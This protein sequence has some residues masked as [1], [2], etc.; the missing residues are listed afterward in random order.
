MANTISGQAL[1]G[2]TITLSGTASAVT[3][4]GP[5]GTY[6]F[7]GLAAGAY[8]V[9]PF[10]Q[11]FAFTPAFLNETIVATDITG[12]NFLGTSVGSAGSTFT[13]Q[14]MIDKVRVF[15]DIEPLFDKV[16]Y[17]DQPSLTIATDVM[18]AICGTPF[19]HKWN[20]TQLP[21]FYTFSYQQDYAL[22]NPDGSSVYNVEWLERGVA[23]DINNSSI[24]KP[25]VDVECG[26]SQPQRTGTF[27][28]SGSM[29]QNPGFIANS[30]PNSDLYYGVWGSPNV[31]NPTLG[32][33]PVAGSVYTNPLGNI[34]QPA[35]PISQI[36]DANGNLLVVT[37]YGTEGTTAPLAAINATPG[38]T[39]SGSGATTVWTVV[40][41]VGLGIRILQVPS[42]TG[43][44]WQFCL[45]GQMPPMVFT[46]ILQN[47]SP[48]PDKYEPFFRAGFIAQCYRYSPEAKI[49]AKFKEEWPLWLKSLS[50]MRV[51]QDRE[52]EEYSFVPDRSIMS[53]GTTRTR[54]EGG[55]WPFN[56]PRP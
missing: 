9:T 35:N 5:T 30:L 15:G 29:M 22:V 36:V 45:V 14:N 51:A 37:T 17:S 11:G 1:A 2:S 16:G 13:I 12:V 50:D 18:T 6:S 26:R 46:S 39:C 27:F 52:L 56:N 44:V 41:P 21:K 28:N 31:A 25:W 24:P 10:K 53:R 32:N 3:T 49:R 19:P 7:P 55:A 43:V 20:Q 4:A 34:S 40:D 42:Q 23:F 33:N 8:V 54:F 47:L 38:T 48:L